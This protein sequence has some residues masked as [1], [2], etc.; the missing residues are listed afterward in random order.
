MKPFKVIPDLFNTII[1]IPIGIVILVLTIPFVLIII[2][3][4]QINKI[5]E[6]RKI[7]DLL[8]SNNGKIYFLYSDYNNYDFTN[9]FEQEFR[10]IKCVKVNAKWNNDLLINHLTKDYG[11]HGYPSVVKIMN[12]KLIVKKHFNSFKHLYKRNN[13]IKTFYGLLERSIKNLKNEN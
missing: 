10:D 5:K 9:F 1:I 11:S 12:D 3:I 6:T 4:T 8:K 2:I 13:D 7:K